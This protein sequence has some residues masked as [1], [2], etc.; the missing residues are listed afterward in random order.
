LLN[1]ERRRLMQALIALPVT[2]AGCG[3][4]DAVTAQSP[5]AGER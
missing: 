3:A 5:T 2:L 1:L 4:A